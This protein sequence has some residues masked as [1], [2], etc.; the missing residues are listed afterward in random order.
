METFTFYL[1]RVGIEALHDTDEAF[2]RAVHDLN[3]V[4]HGVIEAHFAHVHA[5]LI[6]F[7]VGE[8]D[9]AWTTGR[10]SP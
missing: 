4:A 10:Q 6:H 3:V 8:G 2:Q 5:Q 1:F 9:G 7:L